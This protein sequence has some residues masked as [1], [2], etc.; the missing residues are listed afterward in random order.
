MTFKELAKQ[1]T[2]AVQTVPNLVNV[3]RNGFEQMEGGS[4]S[5]H[6]Y[7][8]TEQ[9]IGKWI[10]GSDLYETVVHINALPS[11]AFTAVDY[12][13]NISDIKDIISF[14]GIARNAGGTTKAIDRIWLAENTLATEYCSGCTINKTAIKII[15]GSN[16][17]EY[18]A[19][20]VIQYTKA[21]AE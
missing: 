21:A 1:L 7:S 16:S 11:Q 12:P 3:L 2:S 20:F 5:G 15:C 4:S 17:A 13:H 6:D 10:D 14:T 18:N 8:T 9:K 19:D